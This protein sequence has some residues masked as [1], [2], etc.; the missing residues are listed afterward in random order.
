M[1][2]PPRAIGHAGV[3]IWNRKFESRL[4]DGFKRKAFVRRLADCLTLL[5]LAASLPGCNFVKSVF[6]GPS[7]TTEK[8]PNAVV[9]EPYDTK[10]EVS[11]AIFAD[12]WISAGAL[13]PGLKFD[14]GR[15]TGTPL[16]GGSYG[17]QVS[18]T[19]NSG[20]YPLNDDSRFT[21]LVLDITAPLLAKATANRSYG[22]VTLTA[23]GQ[24]GTV[25]WAITSGVLPEGLLLKETGE[26]QGSA[27]DG[28]NYPFTVTAVDQDSPPRSKSQDLVLNVDNP[29]P[30]I[31]TLDPGSAGVGT[32]SFALEVNGFD[33]VKSSRVFW[34][35]SERPTT[36]LT[37]TKLSAAIPATDLGVPGNPV[38]TVSNPPPAGGL[39]NSFSFAIISGAAASLIRVS[40]DTSGVQSNGPS[41]HPA[42]SANGRFIAFES[43]ASNLVV[44]DANGHSDI[45][46]RDTCRGTGPDCFPSTVRVSLGDSDSEANGPSY[47]PSI[48]ANGRYVVFTSLAS[49]LVAGDT[50]SASNVF[51]RDTCIGASTDCRPRTILVSEGGTKSGSIGNSDDGKLSNS[52]R[53]GA[54]VSVADNLVPGDRNGVADVFLR[55]TCIGSLEPCVPATVRVS[56]DELERPFAT[57]AGDP[58]ISSGGRFVAFAAG[59]LESPLENV[60]AHSS[61][62][63]VRDTCASAGQDC[64]PTTTLV[65]AEDEDGVAL[66]GGIQPSISPDGRFVTFIAAKS[67]SP[68]AGRSE[69]AEVFIRDT[70]R[71]VEIACQSRTS[72][73][74]APVRGIAPDEG[75][76][77]P[78]TAVAGRF[79]AFASRASNLGCG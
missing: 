2:V 23:V 13:P 10:I 28:G 69:V 20:D 64:Y 57:F 43:L 41:A 5:F 79:V 58:S 68:T 51:L 65:P 7:I 36:F 48:S 76:L 19:D 22:P 18:A 37:S 46:V 67:R 56:L 63:Y 17:F 8:I 66:S 47:R 40:V 15:I 35:T 38:I 45:F 12:I 25:N 27:T 9:G 49:N 6:L 70:C 54:F 42:V 1:R 30:G 77:S 4:I 75:S 3:F 21:I 34:D 16:T 74:S 53:Y 31:L 73:L 50:N 44:S 61:R 60:P 55:D 24:V 52:G 59:A 32:A 26:L 71:G 78:A 11:G 72:R 39:S 62:L 29:L 14:G 33:F